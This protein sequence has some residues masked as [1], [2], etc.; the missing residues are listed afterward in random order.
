MELQKELGIPYVIIY[1]TSPT[2]TIEVSKS[3]TLLIYPI[4]NHKV[5]GGQICTKT[6]PKALQ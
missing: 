1:C 4:K 2:H 3:L 6:Q 5:G